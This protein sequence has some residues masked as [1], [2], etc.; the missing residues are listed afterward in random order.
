MVSQT[1]TITT[2]S[3]K[4]LLKQDCVLLDSSGHGTLV[5]WE[6]DIER[7]CLN[8]SYAFENILVKSFQNIKQLSVTDKVKI[9]PL[10]TCIEVKDEHLKSISCN[11][12]TGEIIGVSEQKNT[13][14]VLIASLRYSK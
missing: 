8:E 5:L 10:D 13:I 7:V 4:T 6:G 12:V 3:G 14:V 1:Q 2:K 11:Q 9:K